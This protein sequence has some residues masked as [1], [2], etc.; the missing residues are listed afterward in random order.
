M[1]A[2]VIPIVISGLG[3]TLKGLVKGLEDFEM[4]KSIDHPDYSIT[5]IS[6]NTEKSP[7]D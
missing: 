7:G 1:K 2:T 5:K 6:Q 3:T 4:R